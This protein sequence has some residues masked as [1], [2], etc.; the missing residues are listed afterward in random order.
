MCDAC[1]KPVLLNNTLKSLKM[2]RA[3]ALYSLM[4][5]RKGTVYMFKIQKSSGTCI[6]LENRNIFLTLPCIFRIYDRGTNDIFPLT[7]IFSQNT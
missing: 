2:K 7:R 6:M 3:S 4:I 5:Q 1:H